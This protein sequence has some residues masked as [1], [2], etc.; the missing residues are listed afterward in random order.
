M[1]EA[2][3][4]TKYAKATEEMKS[5]ISEVFVDGFYPWLHY[6]SKDKA[7]LAHTLAHMFNTDSF[8]VAIENS[9][10]I[11]IT[12]CIAKGQRCVKLEKREFRKHLG[13][14]RGSFAYAMLHKEFEIKAYPFPIGERMGAIEFVAVASEYRGKGIA[15]ELIEHIFAVT[16]FLEYVLE[17][18]DTNTAAVH[19][20]RRLGFTEILRVAHTYAKQSGINELVYM[21]KARL[22]Q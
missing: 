20:Y 18:A 21:K 2:G 4:D 8:F 15:T 19:L 10:A 13:L 11:G 6:F 14:I 5:Q 17:V 16:D 12:A 7:T 3:K 1:K 9:K 22:P